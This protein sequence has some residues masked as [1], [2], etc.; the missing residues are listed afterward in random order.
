[1]NIYCYFNYE[2]FINLK[3]VRILVVFIF[4]FENNFLQIYLFMID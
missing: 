1:M 2:F 3:K 4:L